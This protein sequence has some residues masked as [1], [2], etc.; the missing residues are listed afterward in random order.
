[1]K[2]LAFI[3]AILSA[4]G[5]SYPSCSVFPT[6]EWIEAKPEEVELNS[7]VLNEAVN[8]LELNSGRNGTTEL[9]IIR[10]GRLIYQGDSIDKV[11]GVWSC[12]KS[13]T[14]T[15]LG[16]LIDDNRAQLNTMAK[17]IIPQM[18]EIYPE[19]NLS[20]FATMTSG[21]LAEGDTAKKGYTHGSSATPFIPGTVSLFEPGTKYAYWDAAMNQFAHILTQIAKE[22]LDGFFKKRIADPIGMNKNNWYWGD[23][24]EVDGLK[25]VGGAGNLGKGIFISANELARFG[26]LFLNK[27]RWNGNQLIS[28]DWIE[29]ATKVQVPPTMELGSPLSNI[30]GIGV[31]G[32]NWWANGVGSSGSRL[33]PDAPPGT[34]AASGHNNNKMFIIPEWDMVIVRLGL[35]ANDVVITDLIW[36]EFLRKIGDAVEN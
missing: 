29:Q 14:S 23:F 31:Y 8:F 20:H 36:N 30:D 19:V 6:K 27:G 15:I 5:C 16:L 21:Y 13:F 2:L 9:M 7:Q 12:T 32:Y 33:W 24:G 4:S 3:L 35:D 18:A 17:D 22:P 1:M 11:H 25:V 26:L 28:S 34:Y 10:E